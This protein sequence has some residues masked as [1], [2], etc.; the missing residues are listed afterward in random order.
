METL[1]TK[2]PN[3]KKNDNAFDALLESL[4]RFARRCREADAM[5][6]RL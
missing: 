1:F 5:I 3:Q 2:N 4:R 6:R